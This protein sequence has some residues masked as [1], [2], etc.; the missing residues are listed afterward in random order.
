MGDDLAGAHERLQRFEKF[1]QQDPNNI[2]L[3]EDSADLLL[4]LG[5]PKQALKYF[6]DALS[7]KRSDESLRF[8]LGSAYLAS[9]DPERAYGVYK[10]LLA[11]GVAYAAVRY[12]LAYSAF[13]AARPTEAIEILDAIAEPDRVQLPRFSY[14]KA[15]ALYFSR[16]NAEAKSEIE[17]FIAQHPNDLEGLALQSQVMEDAGEFGIAASIAAKVLA[18]NPDDIAANLVAG[19]VCMFMQQPEEAQKY[20][21]KVVSLSPGNGRAWSAM[22]FV[23]VEKR[24]IEVAIGQFQKAVTTMPDH[25]GTWHGLAWCQILRRDFVGARQSVESAMQVDRTFADNHGTLAVIFFFQGKLDEAQ[26]SMKRG[27]RLNPQSAASQFAQSLLISAKGD[28]AAGQDMIRNIVVG[29]NKLP[30]GS[31]VE[32]A[33]AKHVAAIGRSKKLH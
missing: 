27:I 3:L 18:R 19:E 21:Q 6:E 31:T 23:S 24:Q 7:L 14:L 20:L 16:R 29:R 12:N 2:R 28:R 15:R 8:K 32:Q 1:L 13:S 26:Q 9:G 10:D 11:D 30:D 4:E 22:A 25:L 5:R 33:I 17:Q